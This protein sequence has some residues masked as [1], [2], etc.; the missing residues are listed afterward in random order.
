M[1]VSKLEVGMR[2]KNYK[3]LLPYF[4]DREGIVMGKIDSEYADS[5]LEVSL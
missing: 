3:V 2:V 5:L 1:D 4:D